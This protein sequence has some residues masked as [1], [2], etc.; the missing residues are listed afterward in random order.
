MSKKIPL[1]EMFGPTI[2]GEGAVI[3]QQTYFFRFGLCD[4]ECKMCDSLHAV[5]PREVKANA[6]WL[7][8]QEIWQKFH[9]N[10]WQPNST[11][12]VTFS[13]GN[14]CIHDLSELVH[15]LRSHG[16]QINVE[17]Q[18]TFTP[19]WLEHVEIVTVSPKG[20]GMGEHCDLKVLDEFYR[21]VNSFPTIILCTTILCTKIVVFDERDLEFAR[22]IIERYG[23]A[24]GSVYLSLG[25]FQPPPP[26]IPASALSSLDLH[27]SLI[28]AYKKLFDQIK[29]DP[30]LSQVRFLPQLHQLIWGDER[31]R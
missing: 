12:W 24:A 27:H 25:N 3:G 31:G 28:G 19:S 16:F 30:L 29:F 21:Q 11:K 4:Y 8:Q 20:P 14:P 13:G 2:Q 18:G 26:N 23:N 9:R 6:E 7:T 5:L 17:T 22:M 1:V 10:F 15:E